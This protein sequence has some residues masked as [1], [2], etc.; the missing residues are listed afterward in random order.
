MLKTGY[1]PEPDDPKHYNFDNFLLGSSQIQNKVDLRQYSI[2]RR[3]Q[4]ATSSCVAH[5]VAKAVEVRNTIAKGTSPVLSR[6][7]LYFLAR[8][9]MFPKRNTVDQGTYVSTA[10][11]SLRRFGVCEETMWPFDKTKIHRTPTWDAMQKA[12][13]NKID[14]FYKIKANGEDRIHR[15][16]TALSEQYPVVFGTAIGSNWYNYNQDKVLSPTKS[17]K[18]YHA[19]VLLGYDGDTFIGENSWGSDWGSNG[20][21]K[22]DAEHLMWD[23][24]SDFWVLKNG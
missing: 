24:S 4:G 1:I 18:G 6:L 21:Y 12:Y 23:K 11:D 3:N 14:S 17:I 13:T 22:M 2:G 19:T 5:A 15:I 9:L 16:K 10:C 20:F 8:T 7:A